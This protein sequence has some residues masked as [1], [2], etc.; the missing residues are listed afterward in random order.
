MRLLTVTTLTTALLLAACG[1]QDAPAPAPTPAAAPAP[2]P[3]TV[4]VNEVGKSAFGK[5]CALCHA[6]GVGGAPK[7]G[8]KADWGPRIAQGADLLYKHAIEGYNGAKGAM[9]P[10]GGSALPD[11]DVK[12]AVDYMMSLSK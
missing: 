9:P 3:T 8:D 5:A 10:K 11:A 1:K 2:A 12:A 7:P 4:A 6:A